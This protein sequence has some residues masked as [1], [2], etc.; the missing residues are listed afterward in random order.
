MSFFENKN[1]GGM[2]LIINADDF[3]LSKSITDGIINGIKI[4]CITSTTIM[5]NMPYAKYAVE[6]AIKNKLTCVGLHINLTVGKPI[7]ENKNLTDKNGVFLYNRK[8][9]DQNKRLTYDDVYNEIIAQIEII[10]E[11]S[12]GKLQLDHLDTHHHLL[13]NPIIKKVF[14]DICKRYGLPARRDSDIQVK[15]PDHLYH[16]FTIE[17]VNIDTLK[18]FINRNKIKKQTFEIMTHPGWVDDYTKTVTSYIDRDK[19]LLILTEAKESGLFDEVELI[20][21]DKI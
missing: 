2:K 15:M 14:V 19:E 18:K 16:D 11:Y 3:G 9:I 10:K 12:K 8:Q 17:N 21:F 13:D 4:G 7:L 1:G 20:S 5:A 6:Q